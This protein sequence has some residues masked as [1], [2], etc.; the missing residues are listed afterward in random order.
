[1]ASNSP[2]FAHLF[3][4]S[5]GCHV[6]IKAPHETLHQHFTWI[7]YPGSGHDIR[8]LRNSPVCAKGCYPPAGDFIV[9]DG[10][11]PCLIAPVNPITPYREPVR[12]RMEACLSA[13]QARARSII[14]REPLAQWWQWMFFKA[15]EVDPTFVW[16]CVCVW[17]W[18]C[19]C[20]MCLWHQHHYCGHPGARWEREV[21]VPPALVPGDE[22]GAPL[23]FLTWLL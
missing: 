9:G 5:D 6:H 19:V 12:K 17:V 16:L 11:H 22:D 8:A 14:E 2:A 4:P 20:G 13:H 18:V 1:M 3:R 15:L 10:G 7:D 21:P 23:G